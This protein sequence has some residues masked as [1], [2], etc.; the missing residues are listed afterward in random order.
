VESGNR[1][2]VLTLTEGGTCSE[3]AENSALT[4]RPHLYVPEP[5]V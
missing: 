1:K 3:M 2:S 5:N 4:P